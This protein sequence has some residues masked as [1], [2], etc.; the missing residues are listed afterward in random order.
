MGAD[1]RNER[2]LTRG[3][4][5]APLSL[6]C[7]IQVPNTSKARCEKS[8]MIFLL[9]SLLGSTTGQEFCRPL[10][11]QAH[12]INLKAVEVCC[13]LNASLTESCEYSS[14]CSETCSC[15]VTFTRDLECQ[16][17]SLELYEWMDHKPN[18]APLA[19]ARPNFPN[20]DSSYSIVVENSAPRETSSILRGMC[21]MNVT[22]VTMQ[23]FDPVLEELDFSKCFSQLTSFQVNFL[24]PKTAIFSNALRQTRNLNSLSLVNANFE[25]WPQTSPFVQSL[26]FL[27]IENSSLSDLPK[28]LSLSRTL[29]RLYIKNTRLQSLATIAQLPQSKSLT[30]SHNAFDQ[31]QRHV[32]VSTSLVQI[33]LSHNQITSFASHTFSKCADLKI[34]DLSHNPIQVLPY[35]PFVRNTR[36]KWL[37]LSGTKIN[38]LSPEHFA[39]LNSLKT[40]TLSNNVLHSVSPYTFV[41]LKSL[42]HLDLDGCHLARV[43]QAVVFN[44]ALTSKQKKNDLRLNVANNKFQRGSAL[45]P[46]V[47]AMLS[48][49]S[50]LRLDGNALYEFP[51]SLLLISTENVRLLRQL[52]HTSMTLPMWLREPCT[53]YYW[54]MQ[55]RNKSTTL[56]SFLSH[57]DE[58]RMQKNGLGY[59]K[60][61]FEWMAEQMDVYRELEKNSGCSTQRRLRSSL[62]AT[63]SA[64]K[65]NC[66]QKTSTSWPDN[67]LR[68][69]FQVAPMPQMFIASLT[70]NF[71][72]F[73]A[74]FTCTCIS[75]FSNTKKS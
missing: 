3:R 37:K 34:L 24:Q 6:I 15:F 43:P 63:S 41:P 64:P 27:H 55:L 47:M 4:R 38:A 58:E 14:L 8:R 36:L 74:L 60:E 20:Y 22:S 31:L 65:N 42:R 32:F 5:S 26:T 21:G 48:G 53:P 44:C 73:L 46:E 33:D 57:Y 61:Q 69:K 12:G 28:W 52:L 7:R 54:T 2:T 19:C 68:Q 16:S 29:S 23:S 1:W 49:L 62:S 66:S 13:S 51:P 9:F 50:Q 45:P 10:H 18:S 30:L 71:L 35:K 25:F 72:L 59:C 11:A 39:G 67:P 75:C 40:L 17:N 56:K 70:A